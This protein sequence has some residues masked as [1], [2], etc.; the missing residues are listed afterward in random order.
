MSH[1]KPFTLLAGGLLLVLP[2]DSSKPF[3]TRLTKEQQ[4]LH[5][6]DR[7]TFG[8]H[9]ADLERVRLIGVEKWIDE[10]L[11]P[12]RIAENPLL[13]T[14]LADLKSMQMPAAELFRTYPP[15]AVVA[16]MARGNVP[17]PEDPLLRRAIE[18]QVER[19]KVKKAE[20]KQAV[21][22]KDEKEPPTAEATRQK[23]LAVLDVA[24]A[25]TL[26]NGTVDEKRTLLA[27][28]SE[29]KA[30]ELSWLCKRPDVGPWFR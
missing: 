26:R 15:Q 5:V 23:V 12:D 1:I 16:Q 30:D 2:A 10:Q 9:P 21:G 13:A 8:G 28:L 4:A 17:M 3:Q 6:V 11:H 22:E 7:L 27:G 14:K 18:Q 29:P 24:Q 20:G 19:Y 25:K